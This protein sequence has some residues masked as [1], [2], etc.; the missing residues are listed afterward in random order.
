MLVNTWCN[1]SFRAI[2][3]LTFD[4]VVSNERRTVC[5]GKCHS[6]PGGTP[7]YKPYRY[8]PPQRVGVLRRFGLKTGTDFPQFGPESKIGYGFPGNFESVRKYLLFQFQMSSK[9]RE[10]CQF[11]MAFKKS[12][13]LLF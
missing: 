8:V 10:I 6:S 4:W 7:L 2:F 12:F 3:L 11:E 9:E 13:L 1:I 5:A